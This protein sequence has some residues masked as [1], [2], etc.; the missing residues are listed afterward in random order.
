MIS[1]IAEI[2][3]SEITNS[4]RPVARLPFFREK[5]S[6][7][8]YY[9]V[10][11]GVDQNLENLATNGTEN[12]AISGVAFR[13]GCNDRRGDKKPFYAAASSRAA[14]LKGASVVSFLDWQVPGKDSAFV[15]CKHELTILG[16]KIGNCQF[17]HI[18]L[19]VHATQTRTAGYGH[20]RH[21]LNREFDLS[22]LRDIRCGKCGVEFGGAVFNCC[23]TGATRSRLGA[24][25]SSP[26][27]PEPRERG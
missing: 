21:R 17:N 5:I 9:R 25:N 23:G 11:N 19:A 13:C 18:L 20:A 6:Q 16:A 24:M 22:N 8:S 27:Y 10:G 26:L 12:A 2:V 14:G 4:V 15:A 3:R 1:G 7:L